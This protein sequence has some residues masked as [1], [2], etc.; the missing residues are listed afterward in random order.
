MARHGHDRA[1]A[2]FH[3]HEVRDPHRKI[4]TRERVRNFEAGVEAQLFRRFQLGRGRAAGLAELDEVGGFMVRVGKGLRDRVIGGNRNEAGTKDRVGARGIDLDRLV[5]VRTLEVR[6]QAGRLADP[7]FLHHP[8]LFRPLVETV[9]P[10]EQ[11]VGELRDLE[12]PLRQ[13]ALLDQCARTPAAPVDD[14]F[15]GQH[16]HV[17]RVPV[18]RGFAAIDKAMLVEFKKE[19]L[20]V[21]VVFCIAGRELAAPVEREAE[22]LQLRLHV[23][24]VLARPAAWVHALFHGGVF[25][26]HAER[27]PAHRVEYFVPG[28]RLE[29][30]Q[31]VPHRVISHVADVDAPRR[32]GEHL[33]HVALRLVA[34][35]IRAEDFCLVPRALPASVGDRRIETLFSHLRMPLAYDQPVSASRRSS[36]A[37]VRMMSSSFWIV[38]AWT[39]DAT[40]APPCET[41]RLAATRSASAR[42]S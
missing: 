37:R 36:R 28:H 5:E 15:V 3:Q 35:R 16:G 30:R 13:L 23:G 9:Q 22:A 32:I 14:L 1:G 4:F 21:A 17:D 10:F 25:G 31:H 26:R 29:A 41:S 42:R 19:R 33:K 24:D 6:L 8:D 27:V 2:V 11:V 34:V 20:F 18:H 38:A 7:V 39:G 40:H 12:E